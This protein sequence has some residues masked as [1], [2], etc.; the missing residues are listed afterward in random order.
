MAAGHG[1]GYTSGGRSGGSLC[2]T[3]TVPSWTPRYPFF[4]RGEALLRW[5]SST[6]TCCRTMIVGVVEVSLQ[7]VCGQIIEAM[8]NFQGL[9]VEEGIRAPNAGAWHLCWA[10]VPSL[11]KNQRVIHSFNNLITNGLKLDA[12]GPDI[13]ESRLI[14][15]G[16]HLRFSPL[17][18]TVSWRP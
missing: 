9:V 5:A 10:W 3:Q 4:E 8:H 2:R 13:H 16:H 14:D 15:D 6:I 11:N 18:G 17:G 12:G 1:T 7:V